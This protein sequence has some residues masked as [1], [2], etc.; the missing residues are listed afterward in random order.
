TLRD[1]RDFEKHVD[2]IHWNPVKHSHVVRVAD[3]PYSTFHS[4]VE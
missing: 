3:W 2:Y 4:L 1:D